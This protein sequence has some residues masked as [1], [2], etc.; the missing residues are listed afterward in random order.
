MRLPAI[1]LLSFLASP[2]WADSIPGGYDQVQDE[3]T[4]VTRRYKLN[5]IGDGVSCADNSANRRTNCTISSGGGSGDVTAVGPGCATGACWTDGIATAGTDMII[6]EG[7]TDNTNELKIIS[8]SADPG[9]D[10][11]I[12]LPSATTTLV[13]RDTTD[14][15]TNKSISGGQITSAVA[16]ATSL[17]ANGAN[18]SASQYPLGVDAS[19]A[20]E[21]CTALA[22]GNCSG[23][24]CFSGSSGSTLTFEGAAHDNETFGFDSFEDDFKLT[25]DLNIYDVEPHIT[26]YDEDSG[27]DDFHFYADQD[28]FHLT[29]YG[30]AELFRFDG[31]N[32]L[33]LPNV[34][35]CDTLKTDANGQVTC[36]TPRLPTATVCSAGPPK[37]TY[38]TIQGAL[39]AMV[40]G[41]TIYLTDAGYVLTS[42]LKYKYNHQVIVGNGDT[43]LEWNGASV[44]PLIQY[45][46]AL[47]NCGMRN[48]FLYQNN[49][50]PQSVAI[51]AGNGQSGMYQN[52]YIYGAGTA[53]RFTST[54]DNTYYNTVDKLTCEVCN[55]GIEL[56]GSFQIND[57]AFYGVHILPNT[58][59]AG[60]GVTISNGSGNSFY[61]LNVEP[62]NGTGITGIAISGSNSDFNNFHGVWLETLDTNLTIGAGVEGT[63]FFGGTINPSGTI[64]DSGSHTAYLGT[65]KSSTPTY[66]VSKLALGTDGVLFY[67]DNDGALTILGLGNGSDEDIVLNLDDVSNTL[68]VSSSTSLDTIALTGIG[69]TS[70]KDNFGWSIVDGT[71]NTACT[72]QCTFGAVHGWDGTTP[73]GPAS[74]LADICLCAGAN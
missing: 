1:I 44:N 59:G 50:T 45:D 10:I 25:N 23:T 49:A 28:R 4:A 38:S 15:L 27:H 32:Q 74:A 21:S 55:N 58:G 18:C 42:P 66:E 68:G 69:I 11:N 8:P 6:W 3:G 67:H 54:A 31:S 61:N 47:S 70:T 34:T 64:T 7:T 29:R 71:D 2:A 14:T 62:A 12:T 33:Y 52:L 24:T 46:R 9:S 41:G 39:N 48:L 26:F 13:G 22:F 72:S 35:S 43:T 73:V 51:D 40:D 36:G 37:C 65:Y 30:S 60:T 16:N 20:A 53:M 57:N 19:G 63:V 5:F 56:S 17:A